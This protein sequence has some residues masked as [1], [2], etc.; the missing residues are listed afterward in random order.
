M[1]KSCPVKYCTEE[2]SSSHAITGMMSSSTF[3][4]TITGTNLLNIL[5]VPVGNMNTSGVRGPWGASKEFR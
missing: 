1:Y 4:S 2:S 5:E 3:V